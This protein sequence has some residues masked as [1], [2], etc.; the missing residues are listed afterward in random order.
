MSQGYVVIVTKFIHILGLERYCIIHDDLD[1]APEPR[2]DIGLQKLND[3]CVGS[4]PCGDQFDP[5]GEL[6]CGH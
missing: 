5:F 6:V 3:N 2:Q 4:F 1:R